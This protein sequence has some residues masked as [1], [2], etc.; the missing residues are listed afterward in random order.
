MMV[1]TGPQGWAAPEARVEV[2]DGMLIITQTERMHGKI[3]DVI[4]RLRPCFR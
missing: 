4:K 2:V 1:M 3:A